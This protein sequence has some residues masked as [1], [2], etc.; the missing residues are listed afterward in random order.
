M[1]KHQLETFLIV[2]DNEEIRQMLRDIIKDIGKF[3]EEIIEASDGK[4]ALEKINHITSDYILLTD[5]DMP[6]MNGFNL[7]SKAPTASGNFLKG[8][9]LI[10]GQLHQD[11]ILREIKSL[12]DKEN[13]HFK[14]FQK[15]FEAIKIVKEIGYI[16]NN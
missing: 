13:I 7:I 3:S 11:D 10:S 9:I 5:Y 12:L 4:D 14:F 15:P 1:K 16:I 6:K 8:V 2:D